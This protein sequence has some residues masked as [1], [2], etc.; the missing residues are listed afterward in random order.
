MSNNMQFSHMFDY[1]KGVR[2][3][4]VQT[5]GLSAGA[6]RVRIKKVTPKLSHQQQRRDNTANARKHPEKYSPNSFKRVPVF[7]DLPEALRGLVPLEH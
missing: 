3:T 1:Y 7:D 6:H 2:T 4:P 5:E